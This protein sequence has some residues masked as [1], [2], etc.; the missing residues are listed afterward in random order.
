MLSEPIEVVSSTFVALFFCSI[1]ASEFFFSPELAKSKSTS[2]P[3]SLI[4]D[5]S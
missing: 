4:T 5:S 2:S 1:K 3:V